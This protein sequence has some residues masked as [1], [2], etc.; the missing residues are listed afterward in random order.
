MAEK[1][2]KVALFL[3]LLVVI[4]LILGQLGVINQVSGGNAKS[5]ITVGPQSQPE[6]SA[7]ASI[8]VL[9]PGA[10]LAPTFFGP[11]GAVTASVTVLPPR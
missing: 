2:N 5:S 3:V 4:A 9:S 8:R 11:S 1:F 7:H 6:G 10:K